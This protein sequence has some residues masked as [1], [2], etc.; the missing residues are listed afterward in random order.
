[1]Y[2]ILEKG[3]LIYSNSGLVITCGQGQSPR[4]GGLDVKRCVREF[5]GVKMFRIWVGVLIS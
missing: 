3:K 5:G 1:M 4:V 2:V